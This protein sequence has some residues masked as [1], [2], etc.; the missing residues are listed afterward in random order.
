MGSIG[1]YSNRFRDDSY[2]SKRYYAWVC[3]KARRMQCVS[4]K[5]SLRKISTNQFIHY[6][7]NED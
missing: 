6:L 4:I 2:L 1:S 5:I 7:K 3:A